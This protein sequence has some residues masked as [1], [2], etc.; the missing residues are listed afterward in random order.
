M[1]TEVSGNF[2]KIG[3][4]GEEAR[5]HLARGDPDRPAA[6]FNRKGQD[7]LYLS[8]DKES[9]RVAIGQYVAEDDPPRV[10]LSFEVERCELFDLREPY[11]AA[12]Y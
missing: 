7:A 12:T 10:L 9:A 4:A 1:L 6:R 3:L 2:F 5:I 8:P 11:A